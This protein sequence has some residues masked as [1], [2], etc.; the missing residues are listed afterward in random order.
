[1]NRNVTRFGMVVW[2]ELRA[3]GK[4]AVVSSFKNLFHTEGSWAHPA[5]YPMGTGGGALSLDVKRPGREA[6]HSPPCSAEVKECVELYLH[7]H[8]TSSWRGA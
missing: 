7:F 1:M 8:N 3:I 5:S 2:D 6:N 4:E